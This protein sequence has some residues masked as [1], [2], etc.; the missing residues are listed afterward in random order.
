[1]ED[2]HTNTN[3]SSMSS[4]DYTG[5][6]STF[7]MPDPEAVTQ[8]PK[9]DPAKYDSMNLWLYQYNVDEEEPV[10]GTMGKSKSLVRKSKY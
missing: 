6:T 10:F 2:T 7:R 5:R 1:M 4:F 3:S 8:T 9:Y